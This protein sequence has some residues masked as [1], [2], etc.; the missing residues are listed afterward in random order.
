ME[1]EM[2]HELYFIA[3]IAQALEQQAT[4]ES[5]RQAFA[6][7]EA[8]GE[9]PG[10][11][12]GFQQFRQFMDAVNRQG[13]TTDSDPPPGTEL[14]QE[15]IVAL[16]TES[17]TGSDADKKK[18]LSL[19]QANPQWR[20]EYNQLLAEIAELSQIPEA[21]E[22]S[23]FHENTLM[24]SLRFTGLP[25]TQGIDRVTA[26]SYTITDA[27]GRV[28]WEGQLGA[29]E[30]L[31]AQ[32]YPGKPVKLAAETAKASPPPTKEIRLFDVEIIIRV[33]AGIESGRMELTMNPPEVA[34]E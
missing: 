7:I 22:I 19:I 18:A 24:Q 30:L 12:Q 28:I 1:L 21:V 13:K 11:E 34:S 5:L 32:A 15:L 31:W 4:Q 6:E 14:A 20:E 10:Y 33:F 2:S 23:V 17:F 9:K 27:T 8:L 3:I 25:G 29:E 26:G 16:A